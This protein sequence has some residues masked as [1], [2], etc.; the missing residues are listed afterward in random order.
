MHNSNSNTVALPTNYV[1]A[2]SSA[3]DTSNDVWS[4]PWATS[5]VFK[6]DWHSSTQVIWNHGSNP[7]TTSD[8]HTYLKIDSNKGLYFGYNSFDSSYKNEVYIGSLQPVQNDWIGVYIG[9]NGAKFGSAD[10]TFTN[11][12]RTFD[13][14]V[15]SSS[16]YGGGSAWDCS[17][18]YNNQWS[19]NLSTFGVLSWQS[20]NTGR[21][22]IGSQWGQKSFHGKIAS[23][24][25]TT[26]RRGV[27]MPDTT[28]INMMIKDPLNWLSTYKDGQNYRATSE[29]VDRTNFTVGDTSN[30]NYFG[31]ATQ[32]YLM[33]DGTTDS[34]S[35]GIR[36]QVNKDLTWTRAVFSSMVSNDIETVNINGLT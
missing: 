29:Y 36:N 24:I 9:F 18:M 26:L 1:V 15:T 2:S 11:L 5:V 32:V 35:N 33:G 3:G 30:Y 19:S 28:E 8:R 25:T 4:R 7:A 20:Y 12:S 13:I 31:A 10:A 27:A 21:L 6:P 14:R 23:F 22:H 17:N 34:Y 16:G